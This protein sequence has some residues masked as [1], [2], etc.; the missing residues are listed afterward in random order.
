MLWFVLMKNTLENRKGG[1][2]MSEIQALLRKVEKLREQLHVIVKDRDLTDPTVLALSQRLDGA[3]NE[4][5]LVTNPPSARNA[6]RLVGGGRTQLSPLSSKLFYLLGDL[7]E[8]AILRR[9]GSIKL[10]SS[11]H[12]S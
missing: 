10:S 3:L 1:I 9:I 8:K 5:R 7:Q 12:N 11:R 2:R 4:Y 6:K